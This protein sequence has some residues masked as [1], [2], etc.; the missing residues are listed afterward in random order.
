WK[1][2]LGPRGVDMN[3]MRSKKLSV[4]IQQLT[5]NPDYESNAQALAE[6][7]SGIDGAKNAVLLFEKLQSRLPIKSR[8]S[9]QRALRSVGGAKRPGWAQWSGAS[10]RRRPKGASPAE[11]R[12]LEVEEADVREDDNDAAAGE[13]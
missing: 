12:R 5:Q 9:Y 3:R 1:K 11:I 13:G 7:V 6:R 10:S 8:A 2:A 4:A